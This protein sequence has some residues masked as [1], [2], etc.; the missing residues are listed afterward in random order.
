MRRQDAQRFSS[1]GSGRQSPL[2]PPADR[3]YVAPVTVH[4]RALGVAMTQTT[5]DTGESGERGALKK[6][7]ITLE[8]EGVLIQA[9]ALHT[10]RPFSVVPGAG[11]RRAPDREIE[12]GDP[13]TGRSRASSRG[14]ATSL[15]LQAITRNA[16]AGTRS[17]SYRQRRRRSTSRRTGRAVPGSWK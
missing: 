4:A 16:T 1:G 13:P 9:D 8:L 5:Y 11:G 7:L 17:G 3:V 15:S 2:W 14:S 12:P 10:T 6:L